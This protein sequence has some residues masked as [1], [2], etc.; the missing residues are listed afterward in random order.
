MSGDG[1]HGYC[2]AVRTVLRARVARLADARRSGVEK[3]RARD[4]HVALIAKPVDEFP[5]Q[6]VDLGVQHPPLV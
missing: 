6:S 1:W 5:A 4:D 3:V 2:D